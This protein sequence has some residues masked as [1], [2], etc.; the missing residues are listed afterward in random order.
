MRTFHLD[1]FTV[2]LH[3]THL[4][5]FGSSFLWRAFLPSIVY[6]ALLAGPVCLRGQLP[7]PAT[8]V[9][10]VKAAANP[11]PSSD[12]A[13]LPL[14][15][16]PNQGQTAAQV[17][18]QAAG[19]GYSIFLTD[20]AAVLELVKLAPASDPDA[21][22]ATPASEPKAA[23]TD[24]IR[25]ELAGT[26]PHLEPAADDQLPG[27][28]NYFIG[29]DP[30]KWR[31]AIPTYAKVRYPGIY[32]GIDLVYYGNQQQ[33]EYDFVVAPQANAGSIR[34]SFKGGEK[35]RLGQSGRSHDLGETR[36]DRLS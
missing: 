8:D 11:A 26:K 17:R 1:K 34:L 18:F 4:H 6:A 24:F 35:L 21:R 27:R 22:T 30:A 5:G 12:F 16:V 19:S 7:S 32:P 33:L 10:P 29:N 14:T 3:L 13:K 23:I 9:A 31:R 36:Q 25:M 15:F 20:S 28:V 2:A